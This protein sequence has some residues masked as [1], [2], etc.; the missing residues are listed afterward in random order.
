VVHVQ[1]GERTGQQRLRGEVPE[2]FAVFL[3][4]VPDRVEAGV[5]AEAVLPPGDPDAGH[6]PAQVPFP[7]AGVGLVEVVQVEDEFP[8]RGG[9]EA[10]IAQVGVAADDRGDAGVRQRREIVGH[11]V[12]RAAEERVGRGDHA[13]DPDRDQ[14]VEP[15]LVRLDDLLDGVGPVRGRGPAAQVGAGGTLTP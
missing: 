10:E 9:V 8:F 1:G 2:M 14:P 15:A 3:D 6:Q 13:A 12:G 11:D 4:A 5:L 7:G